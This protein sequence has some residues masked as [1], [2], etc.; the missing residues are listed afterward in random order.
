MAEGLLTK[1]E[2][3]ELRGRFEAALDPLEQKRTNI[4]D[5]IQQIENGTT[6]ECN[7]AEQFLPYAG[8]TNFCRKDVA[9]LVETILLYKD[10]RIEIH[11]V[12]EQDFRYI[13]EVLE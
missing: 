4:L 6:L 9:M 8:Q 7:W 3:D 12:H 10:K 1:E 13:W 2:A 5:Q 11:F